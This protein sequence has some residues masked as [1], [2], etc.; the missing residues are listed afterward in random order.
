[1][2]R[3]KSEINRLFAS[4]P[5]IRGLCRIV[6]QAAVPNRE[7][8]KI[9]TAKPT[10]LHPKQLIARTDSIVAPMQSAIVKASIVSS[11]RVFNL[12]ANQT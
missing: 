10:G 8:R 11:V 1:M 12:P 2:S 7:R 6:P 9:V 3:P 5:T 4:E